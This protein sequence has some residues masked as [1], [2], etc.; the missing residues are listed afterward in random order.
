MVREE[1]GENGEIA[2]TKENGEI[3]ERTTRDRRER[4][5]NNQ[6]SQREIVWEIKQPEIAERRAGTNE[7]R[8]VHPIIK[9]QE[10]WF[11]KQGLEFEHRSARLTAVPLILLT[12][13]LTTAPNPS[14]FPV[15][16]DHL[17]HLPPCKPLLRPQSP[18]LPPRTASSHRS[19][20]RRLHC[21][22]LATIASTASSHQSRLHRL[23]CRR[24]VVAVLGR[25]TPVALASDHHLSSSPPTA[26]TSAAPTAASIASF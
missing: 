5:S 21:R 3:A 12:P 18:S 19:R 24:L 25:P 23:Y 1:R 9:W 20:L 11:L 6:R 13:R 2:E 17:R 4:R 15:S 22:Q 14:P 8:G 7:L 26:R 16:S 10:A